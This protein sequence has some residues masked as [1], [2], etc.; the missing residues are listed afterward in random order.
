MAHADVFHYIEMFYN[1]IRCHSHL[2]GMS[3]EAFESTSK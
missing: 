2:D 1:R 3:P